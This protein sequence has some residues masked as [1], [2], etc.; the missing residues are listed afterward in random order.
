MFFIIPVQIRWL[1]ALSA[2]FIVIQVINDIWFLGFVLLA[3]TN[4]FLWA[5]IPALRG[6]AGVAKAVQRRRKFQKASR[7]DDNAFH[8]CA[9]CD[10][11]ELS[12]PELE[13]RMAADGKEYCTEHLKD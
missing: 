10:R 1:A 13:F 2:V 11:T 3:L 6:Q 8:R 5:G 4:Y 7:M 9:E 12:D